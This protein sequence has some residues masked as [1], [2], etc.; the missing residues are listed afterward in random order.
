MFG[1]IVAAGIPIDTFWLWTNE[2][3][4]DHHNGC[5]WR[6]YMVVCMV[7][8]MVVFFVCV[9]MLCVVVCSVHGLVHVVLRTVT[10]SCTW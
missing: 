5:V 1:R 3:V 7:V 10:C 4:E 6:L 9:V 8:Y 2:G